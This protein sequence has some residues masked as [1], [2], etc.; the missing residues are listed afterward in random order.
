MLIKINMQKTYDHLKWKFIEKALQVW[1]F[2]I[3]G[4]KV[5][6]KLHLQS[7]L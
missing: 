2:F 1:G 7:E 4:Y 6:Y 5:L 3:V